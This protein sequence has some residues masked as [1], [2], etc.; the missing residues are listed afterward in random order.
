MTSP[1]KE[2]QFPSQFEQLV[3]ESKQHLEDSI[4]HLEQHNKSWR[5]FLASA[6]RIKASKEW[7]AHAPT[8]KEF[9][10]QTWG[11]GKQRRIIHFRHLAETFDLIEEQ[12]NI[13]L[14]E[15]Q[16]K[17]LQ[18]VVKDPR[19]SKEMVFK[20]ALEETKN[21]DGVPTKGDF[22]AAQS[23]I[24]QSMTTGRVE[25]RGAVYESSPET[26]RLSASEKME[27]R[28][29]V[30][31]DHIS[32]NSTKE[33]YVLRADGIFKDNAFIAPLSELAS[34]LGNKEATVYLPKR[35]E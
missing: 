21:P 8:W 24:V 31:R 30:Q 32:E 6:D 13:A 7:K 5:L 9:C 34:Y 16:A 3:A 20:L 23:V 14:N 12:F 27:D 18:D 28:R 33:K 17:A 2:I 29:S 35:G 25:I 4:A 15:S 10:N 22:E 19:I 26:I 1:L 11:E